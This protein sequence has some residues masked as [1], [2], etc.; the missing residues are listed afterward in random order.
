MFTSFFELVTHEKLGHTPGFGHGVTVCSVIMHSRGKSSAT[1]RV[2]ELP[3]YK[4]D[5]DDDEDDPASGNAPKQHRKRMPK[6]NENPFEFSFENT[7][8]SAERAL[9]GVQGSGLVAVV[10]RSSIEAV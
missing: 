8:L 10:H 5:M 9:R 1:K 3:T 4:D 2:V 7:V 6:K